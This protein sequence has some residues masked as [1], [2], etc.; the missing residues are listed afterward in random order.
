MTTHVEE[1]LEDLLYQIDQKAEI[2]KHQII[3][4]PPAGALPGHA[5]GEIFFS[6]WEYSKQHKN[7]RAF[8]DNTAF[9]MN[10]PHR[11]SFSPCAGF[12]VGAYPKGFE[13]FKARRYLLLRFATS[14][15]MGRVSNARGRP[16]ALITLQPER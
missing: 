8:G 13:F 7:G 5:S 3:L 11:K 15:T 6:L 12:Y 4:L 1:T 16:S 2:V 14:L 9:M 10:L